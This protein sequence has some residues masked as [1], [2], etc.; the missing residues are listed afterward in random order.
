MK[1]LLILALVAF[2]GWYGWHHYK[3]LMTGGS[4]EAVIVNDSGIPMDRVRLLVG[5]Q[6][7]VKEALEPG[8]SAVLPFRC[9]QDGSF[10]LEWQW[11]TRMGSPRWTGG[12]FVHGPLLTRH[13][14][15]V[16]PE[17]GVVWQSERKLK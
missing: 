15:T 2:A 13:T 10:H 11:R 16:D 17:G 8:E 14:F 12:T 7:L 6:T 1:R 9:N 4:H 3:Q 5:D